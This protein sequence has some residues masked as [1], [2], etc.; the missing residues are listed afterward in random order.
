MKRFSTIILALGMVFMSSI[1]LQAED[2]LVVV[3]VFTSATCPPCAPAAPIIHRNATLDKGA[4]AIKHQVWWPSPGTD[5][6]FNYSAEI[7]A[8]IQNRVQ[9]YG[10]SGVPDA[11]FDGKNSINPNDEQGF[12]TNI[13]NARKVPAPLKM[14]VVEDRTDPQN[15]KVTVKVTNTSATT[16]TDQKLRVGVLYN[17]VSIPGYQGITNGMTDFY[18]VLYKI[19][20]SA[21]GENV[22]LEPNKEVSYTYTY[23]PGTGPLWPKG[24]NFV[25]AYV[26]DPASKTI[27]Q[28][29][30]NKSGAIILGLT[31]DPAGLLEANATIVK[32]VMVANPTDVEVTAKLSI[33]PKSSL[34][35]GW[36]ATLNQETIVI[37]AKG[38]IPVDVSIV[39]NDKAGFVTLI[40][41]AE[42]QPTQQNL[43]FAS[44]T[45]ISGL[46]ASAKY[47]IYGGTNVWDGDMLNDMQNMDKIKD[48][49]A[50]IP[51][52]EEN[53]STYPPSN[54]EVSVFTTDQPN[55]GALV[56][57]VATMNAIREAVGVGKKVL[58]SSSLDLYNAFSSSGVLPA[59]L[60]FQQ[61]LGIANGGNPIQRFTQSGNNITFN[62]F[63]LNGIDND[64]IS[65]GIKL[66]LNTNINNP[67]KLSTNYYTD[68]IRID[69]EELAKTIFT[70]ES[71]SRIGGVRVE[72]GDSRVVYLSFGL[73]AIN[74]PASRKMVMERCIDWLLG[75]P[76]AVREDAN[77]MQSIAVVPNTI[78]DE[79]TL[80]YN[81]S[82]NEQDVHIAIYDI[83]G[84]KVKD[85]GEFT[86]TA[87]SYEMPIK[88]TSL[89]NGYYRIVVKSGVQSLSTPVSILR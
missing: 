22:T 64:P 82:G 67:S 18:D 45:T 24:Q 52:T 36:K 12:I 4:I 72:N 17:H 78:S 43:A 5:P 76:S 54:F 14:S 58:I 51:L 1:I 63:P 2:R 3:E 25:V 65:N 16:L 27:H 77:S 69:N 81:V 8:T 9:Y 75:A 13:A 21:D 73:E 74:D 6:F 47:V 34:P 20:P 49:S 15:I 71:A 48:G 83:L 56:V 37:P 70:F 41:N 79:A 80:R 30:T 19:L 11:Y 46:S 42:P 23:T 10:V 87:G 86:Q 88:T 28:G 68:I 40:I 31:A 66:T 44:S 85:L 38:T 35:N 26:Q 55:R 61:D 59:Q 32:K 50:M 84:N 7:K 60:F 29:A 89:A 62:S 53:I 39:S 57:D 33:D